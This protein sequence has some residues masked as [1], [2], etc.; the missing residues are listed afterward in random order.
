MGF[1]DYRA[2][3]RRSVTRRVA[4][5]NRGGRGRQADRPGPDANG[6]QIVT[7]AYAIRWI[8]AGIAGGLCASVF[9]PIALF[10]P[11]PLPLTVTVAA[12]LGPA[13]GVGSMGLRYLIVLHDT[14]VAATLAA[15]TNVV[16]GALLTAMLLVQLAVRYAVAA[17]SPDA[18]IVAVWLGLDVAWDIYIGLGTLLFAAAMIGHPRFGWPFALPGFI[19]AALVLVLNI[20]TFPTPPAE[21][22]SFDVGPFVGL[23]YLA[24]TLQAWRSMAWA[25]SRA[26]DSP[27]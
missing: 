6:V 14:S 2:V 8:Q 15:L 16:A 17:N 21:A 10:V 23:W 26:S 9:Y 25:R 19:A 3:R 1:Q 4:H 13:I 5:A 20:L 12:F 22:G 27:A 24:A 11:L 7:Q 18:S